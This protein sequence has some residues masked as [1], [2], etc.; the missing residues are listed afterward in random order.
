M[1]STNT[2]QAQ[3]LREWALEVA[4]FSAQL[5]AQGVVVAAVVTIVAAV[6]AA[7]VIT[8]AVAV[9]EQEAV[10]LEEDGWRGAAC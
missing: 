1:R 8:V 3:Q 2:A 7:A 5:Q 9:E 10:A 6:A 4:H